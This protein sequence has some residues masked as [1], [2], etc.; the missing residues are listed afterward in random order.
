M[1]GVQVGDDEGPELP[2]GVD[3]FY[4]APGQPLGGL[5]ADL[6]HALDAVGAVLVEG[7]RSVLLIV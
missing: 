6:F 4:A 7:R 2:A 3:L 1:G 5:A